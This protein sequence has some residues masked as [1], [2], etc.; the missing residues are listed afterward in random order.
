MAIWQFTFHLVPREAVER[1]HGPTAIVLAAFSQVDLE[2]HDET[3]E[4]P[5]YWVMLTVGVEERYLRA[6]ASARRR[7]QR[8]SARTSAFRGKADS[9]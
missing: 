5:N 1:L 6:T 4:P 8:M 7:S 2:T 3:A 9:L